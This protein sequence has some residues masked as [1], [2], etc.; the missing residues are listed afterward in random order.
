MFKDRVPKWTHTE[1]PSPGYGY[2]F[3]LN[4]LFIT[5]PS[6]Y[7]TL[8]III[9]KDIGDDRIKTAHNCQF[10]LSYIKCIPAEE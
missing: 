3:L 8:R 9:V 10:A 1:F 2:E 7:F 5:Y 4:L 6:L